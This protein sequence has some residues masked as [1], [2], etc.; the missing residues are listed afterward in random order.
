M[1]EKYNSLQDNEVW[2]LVPLPKGTKPIGCRWIFKTKQDANGNMERYKAC[3]M[4]KGF[5]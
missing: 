2:E 1:N 5:I 3:L 4:A